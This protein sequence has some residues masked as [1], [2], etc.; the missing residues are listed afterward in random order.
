[1]SQSCNQRP[2]HG[3][4]ARTDASIVVAKS[5]V[6]DMNAHFLKKAKQTCSETLNCGLRQSSIPMLFWSGRRADLICLMLFR[7]RHRLRYGL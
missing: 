4:D 3:H 1:L 2:L 6:R 5:P 7:F